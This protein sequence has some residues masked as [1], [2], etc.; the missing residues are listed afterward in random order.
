MKRTDLSPDE[1]ELLHLLLSGTEE[2]RE[3]CPC[4]PPEFFETD[5]PGK[6]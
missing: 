5:E 6:I 4:P 3:G 2:E 1:G